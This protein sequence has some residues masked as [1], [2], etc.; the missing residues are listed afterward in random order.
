MYTN[1]GDTKKLIDRTRN[2]DVSAFETLFKRHRVRSQKAIAMRMDR[3]VAARVD[4]S[5]ILQ[6]TYMEAFR[7]FPEYLKQ[8]KMSF[9]LRLRWIARGKLIGQHRR[10]LSAPKRSVH[11]EVPPMPVDSS[12]EFVSGLIGRMPSPSRELARKELAERL[13]MALEQL[14]TDARDLVLWRHFEQLSAREMAQLLN[15]TEA[16]ANKRYLRAVERL[17]GILQDSGLSHPHL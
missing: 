5:D 6:E 1:P 3:R 12:A 14:D 15:L 4:D 17:R 9:Y 16:A 7:R 11:Y 8:E 2:G 10:H 13:R